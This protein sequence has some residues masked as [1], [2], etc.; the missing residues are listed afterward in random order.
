MENAN[1]LPKIETVLVALTQMTFD[2][3]ENRADDPDEIGDLEAGEP[4]FWEQAEYRTNLA[5]A[6]VAALQASGRTAEMIRLP[7]RSFIPRDIS[8]AAF[9]WRLVDLKESNGRPID[10]VVCL[11][12]PAW[13]LQHP[14]KCCWLTALPNFVTRSRSMVSPG[15][16]P[17]GPPQK[18]ISLSRSDR[19]AEDA[20]A[21][22]G[23]LQAER[24]GL[25]ESRRVLAATRPLAEEMARRGLQVEF[26]P[27]PPDL[28]LPPTDPL[29]KAALKR[30]LREPV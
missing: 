22:A 7:Q 4:D 6:L 14:A 18:P 24:R 25:A 12:F 3:L 8:K 23:L 19:Q 10:L 1:S 11:D 13:S 16:Y 30:L 27:V 29:W 20:G 9:A 17:S 2:R 26:N 28:T 21:I 5:G 15:G